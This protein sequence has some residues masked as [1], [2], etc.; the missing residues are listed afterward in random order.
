MNEGA[1]TAADGK[2]IWARLYDWTMSLAA[3]RHAERW[4]AA[5]STAESSF[6][7]VPV[8]IVLAPM[9]MAERSRAWRY[10]AVAAVFSVLGGVIGFYIGIY[11]IDAVTPLLHRLNYWEAYQT[12]ESWF[13]QWGF[14][15]VLVA[16]FTPIPYKVFTI[17]AGASGMALIPFVLASLVGRSGRFFL[18]AGLVY[19]FGQR[20]EDRLLRYI[21]IIGWVTL[22]LIV[23]AVGIIKFT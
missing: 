13:A 12:A 2:G 23:I 3:H 7:P 11:L 17:A 21:D 1:A 9:V 8:D 15:T 6:F 14:W 19:A 10:A 18:V 5:I 22:A 4:L 16:G 20:I